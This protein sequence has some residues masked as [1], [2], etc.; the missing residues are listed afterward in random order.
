MTPTAELRLLE[1]SE[2]LP[3]KCPESLANAEYL[4]RIS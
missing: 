2:N 4:E 1:L 3:P